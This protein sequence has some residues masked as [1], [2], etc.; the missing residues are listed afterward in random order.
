MRILEHF[1]TPG[2]RVDTLAILLPGALQ[3]PE[4]MVQAGFVDAVRQRGLAMDLTLVDLGIQF[5]GETTDGAILQR[6]H[7][8]VMQPAQARGYRQLWLGGISIGG[9]MALA[10]ANHFPGMT[11]GLCLIAPYPGNRIL[12]GEI[13]AAGGIDQWRGEPAQAED[14]ERRVWQWLKMQ[15][16]SPTAAAIYMGYGREDRF[17]AGQ[18]MMAQA[19]AGHH[20]DTVEGTHD[21][22]AWQHLWGNFLDRINH[23]GAVV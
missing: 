14:G 11:N 3:R 7:E 19:L 5:I 12:T 21:W 13:K 22:P 9:F 16:A 2:Q 6:L 18:Q 23:K 8:E 20:V 4:D 17:A 10:Y 15:Q 1:A